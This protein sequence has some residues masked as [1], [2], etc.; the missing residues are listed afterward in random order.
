MLRA[1]ALMLHA[2]LHALSMIHVWC[3]IVHAARRMSHA[4]ECRIRASC[5]LMIFGW[6]F[7]IHAVR[8]RFHAA[9][10]VM[11]AAECKI[12]ASCLMKHASCLVVHNFA[13]CFRIHTACRVIHGSNAEFMLRAFESWFMSGASCFMPHASGF[14]LRAS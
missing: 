1:T 6:C 10:P 5:L 9:R 4:F 3:F 13:P 11:Y 7:M 14:M 8:F 2:S 12:L